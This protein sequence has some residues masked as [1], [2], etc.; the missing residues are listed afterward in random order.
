[1][2]SSD[3]YWTTAR[4]VLTP[5]EL[6]ILQLADIHELGSRRIAL[7]LHLKR[8]T[9]RDRLTGIRQKIADALEQGAAA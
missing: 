4:K 9:V 8:T 6:Y 2:T 7:V 1:M 5:D 3:L